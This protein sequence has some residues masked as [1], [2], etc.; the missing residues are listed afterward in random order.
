MF[1]KYHIL[2]AKDRERT[3]NLEG[4]FKVEAA[5]RKAYEN[6]AK[7]LKA[8]NDELLA[9]RLK[10]IKDDRTKRLIYRGYTSQI[11]LRSSN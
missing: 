4:K 6:A 7:Q 1:H 11:I 2:Q 5:K 8:Q 9:Q 10:E 3:A